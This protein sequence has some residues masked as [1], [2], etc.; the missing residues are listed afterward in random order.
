M[1][2][3]PTDYFPNAAYSTV[4]FNFIEEHEFAVREIEFAES[5][6]RQAVLLDSRP[7]RRVQAQMLLSVWDT[8]QLVRDFMISHSGPFVPF[9]VFATQRRKFE[10]FQIG[11]GTGSQGSFSVFFYH[12]GTGGFDGTNA[13]NAYIINVKVNGVLKVLDTDY[14]L[15]SRAAPYNDIFVTFFAGHFP[16]LG[17]AVT[18]TVIGRPRIAVK[19]DGAVYHQEHPLRVPERRDY[20]AETVTLPLIEV[21]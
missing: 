5:R 13:A 9:W 6:R 20:M 8:E 11:T 17:E 21:F 12:T 10:N 4:Q 19:W 16:P 14:T 7:R 18:V 1:P 15:S 3:T 2:E